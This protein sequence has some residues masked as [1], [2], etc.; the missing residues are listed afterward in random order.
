MQIIG[1]GDNII[2]HISAKTNAKDAWNE[3]DKVFGAKA[4]N[5]E[6]SLKIQFYGLNMGFNDSFIEHVSKMKSIMMQLAGIK[7]PIDEK[8]AIA[9]L[10]KSMPNEFSSIV[11][12]LKKSS[13]SYT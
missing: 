5:S 2:H 12:T 11:T 1:L 6:I 13:G 4:K 10:I 7:V 3:L 9:V 8:D